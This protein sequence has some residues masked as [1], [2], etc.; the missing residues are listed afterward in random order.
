MT[1][2]LETLTT[3]VYYGAAQCVQG[4]SEHRDYALSLILWLT[5][6]HK[7][8]ACDF[9]DFHGSQI[10]IPIAVESLKPKFSKKT[11]NI[12]FLNKNNVDN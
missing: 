11:L 9:V 6:G 5:H 3:K 10:L 2:S 4:D 12:T 1:A 8:L 7:R